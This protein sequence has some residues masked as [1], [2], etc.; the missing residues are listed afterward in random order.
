MRTTLLAKKEH[1]R[2]IFCQRL[3]YFLAIKVAIFLARES[4]SKGT[5]TFHDCV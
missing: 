2:E 5:I 4:E 1:F 3:V